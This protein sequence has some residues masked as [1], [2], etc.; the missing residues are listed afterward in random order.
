MMVTVITP[1]NA[2]IFPEYIIPALSHLIRAPEIS[3]R[4]MYAQCVVALAETAVRYLDMG[5]A[6]RAHG[7]YTI[8]TT[9]GLTEGQ[10]YDEAHF[11]VYS[12]PC[13]AS[14]HLITLLSLVRPVNARP[15]E[16]NSRT[17]I[18]SLGGSITGSQTL[19]SAQ[20]LSAMHF[21]RET[22]YQ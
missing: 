19:G 13:V 4:C 2:A 6:L 17:I 7:A 18:R 8:G 16:R 3:V 14:Y 21:P 10:D 22:T 9:A 5:Q 12:N 1:S 11:E 20:H 15:P